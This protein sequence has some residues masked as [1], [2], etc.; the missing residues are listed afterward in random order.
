MLADSLKTLLA[1]T[2]VL[3]FKAH[4]YHPI[5]GGL[6]LPYVNTAVVS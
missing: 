4:S 3:Y 6:F 2:F 5:V 1:D